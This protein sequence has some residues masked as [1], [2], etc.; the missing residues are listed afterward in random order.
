MNVLEPS[1]F[2]AILLGPKTF[3]PEFWKK[4]YI[5]STK[6]FSGPT[7]NNSIF[8]SSAIFLMFPKSSIFIEIFSAIWDVP[9]LPGKQ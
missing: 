7:T 3:I 2:D 8:F 4:S 5:P 9:A 6:G 1:S